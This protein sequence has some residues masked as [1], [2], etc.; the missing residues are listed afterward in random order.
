MQLKRDVYGIPVQGVGELGVTHSVA[1]STVS[2][3][4]TTAFDGDTIRICGTVDCFF[5]V[6]ATP[7]T[8]TADHHYLPAG[9]IEYV[10]TGGPGKKIATIG[11][12]SG[13]LY[14]SEVK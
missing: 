10:N 7:I 3:T 14:V 6:G 11:S 8:A 4:S 9:A 13:T 5:T 2:T 12:T 1:I